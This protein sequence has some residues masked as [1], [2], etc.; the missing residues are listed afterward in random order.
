MRR[1]NSAILI[2][3]DNIFGALEFPDPK[4]QQAFV[5]AIDRWVLWLGDGAFSE[6]HQRRRFLA[7]RVYWNTPFQRFRAQFEAAGFEAFLCEAFAITKIDRGTSTADIVIAMDA[8]QLKS[9]FRDLDEVIILTADSDFIRVADRLQEQGL[10]VVTAG[11]ERHRT[12]ALFNMHADAVIHF[13]ALRAGCAYERTP[14]KWYQLRSPPPVIAPVVR[15]DGRD[16]PLM[17]RVQR[18]LKPEKDAAKLAR[19]EQEV[20]AGGE[21]AS[22]AKSFTLKEIAAQ[23]DAAAKVEALGS[24]IPDQPITR[25][26]IM[27]ALQNVEGFTSGARAKRSFLG[28]GTYRRLM[29]RLGEVN[30]RLDVTVQKNQSVLVILR[31]PVEAETA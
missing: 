25:A 21:A 16:S 26:K 1:L 10:R 3:F 14:R 31:V 18:D 6:N 20:A 22:A 30:P 24:S 13:D 9:K 5:E 7:K 15:D 27:R 17:S 11:N 2:D 4:D 8:V 28:C 23:R 19:L 29:L 12:F